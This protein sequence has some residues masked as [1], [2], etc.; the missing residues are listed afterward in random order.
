MKAVEAPIRQRLMYGT[1]FEFEQELRRV[2]RM[3][4]FEDKIG[5]SKLTE[6]TKEAEDRSGCDAGG[7]RAENRIL[8]NEEKIPGSTIFSK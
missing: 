4:R 5:T 3:G 2:L 6:Q 8:N 7:E 1:G